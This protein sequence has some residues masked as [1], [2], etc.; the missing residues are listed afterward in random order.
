M[1]LAQS[2]VDSGSGIPV[3]VGGTRVHQR[4]LSRRVEQCL[5]STPVILVRSGIHI[6]RNV[7]VVA[8]SHRQVKTACEEVVL[9]VFHA[10]LQ[11]VAAPVFLA[12]H[13][14]LSHSRLYLLVHLRPSQ[15]E[16]QSVGPFLANHSQFS[17]YCLVVVCVVESLHALF[18]VTVY[19]ARLEVLHWRFYTIAVVGII[20]ECRNLVCQSAFEC[21]T[22]TDVRLMSIERTIGIR[23]VEMPSAVTLVGHHVYYTA[24]GIGTE[25]H[26]HHSLIHLY[27]VGKAHWNVVKT[28]R[29]SHTFLRHT[30]DKHF[31]PFAAESIHHQRH[32]GT[33]SSR[34]PQLQT[35]SFRECVAQVFCRI[36]HFLGIYGNSV[37][38]RLLHPAHTTSHNNHLVK[39]QLL[40]DVL[41][42]AS[43]FAFRSPVFHTCGILLGRYGHS[44]KKCEAKYSHSEY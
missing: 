20:L 16:E 39:F 29:R 33:H 36:L 13:N 43:V 40:V 9:H 15:S 11:C 26:W 19:P 4:L 37:E 23:R 1:S 7:A 3:V 18:L 38:C 2:V 22:E 21:L 6:C 44:H 30:V 42:V 8:S 34:L 14:L 10:W 32:V 31:Y 41:A 12:I 24:D 35:G 17:H 27:S 5:F 28:E 25:S